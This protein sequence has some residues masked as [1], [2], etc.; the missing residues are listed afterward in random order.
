MPRH[1][2]GSKSNLRTRT[3]NKLNV[4]WTETYGETIEDRAENLAKG[5]VPPTC[6]YAPLTSNSAQEVF[7]AR[8]SGRRNLR[9]FTDTAFFPNRQ[10]RYCE[11]VPFSDRQ[12]R[13][14]VYVRSQRFGEIVSGPNSTKSNSGG[15][16]VIVNN[17]LQSVY[18]VNISGNLVEGFRTL[19]CS[20]PSQDTCKHMRAVELVYNSQTRDIDASLQ[21]NFGFENLKL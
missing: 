19:T 7:I 21:Y 2:R 8:L 11:Y 6:T 17:V 13:D 1:V 9:Y 14:F 10:F 4:P 16:G 15:I 12:N 3:G 20:C 18:V 5:I